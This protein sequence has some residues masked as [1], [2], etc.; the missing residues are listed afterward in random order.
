MNKEEKYKL[1]FEQISALTEGETDKGTKTISGT[2][3][4]TVTEEFDAIEYTAPG[5]HTY[6]IT[7]SGTIDGITN[8]ETTKT[9][10]VTVEDD[11]EGHLS[12]YINNKESTDDDTTGFDNTYKVT[13]TSI[14]IP[15][16]KTVSSE[17]EGTARAEG[18]LRWRNR[19]TVCSVSLQYSQIQILSASQ[20]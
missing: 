15:V 6:T 13:K 18:P 9:V 2:G 14:I 4:T 17:T 10:T 5:T 11:G 16:K 7:E 20:Q 3:N 19:P 1:L 8:G 12:A